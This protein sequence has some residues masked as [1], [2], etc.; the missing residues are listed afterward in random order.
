MQYCKNKRKQESL[1]LSDNSNKDDKN[2]GK[3]ELTVQ[4][5]NDN[6]VVFETT[7]NKQPAQ[8]MSNVL[9]ITYNR[10]TV[11]KEQQEQYKRSLRHD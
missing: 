3:I 2:T 1:I 6:L 9:S 11:T 8:D 7:D 5:W 4:D 10:V